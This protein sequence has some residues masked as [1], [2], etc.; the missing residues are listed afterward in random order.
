MKP[1]PALSLLSVLLLLL[2]SSPV[3]AVD[4]HNNAPHI[5]PIVFPVG[6]FLPGWKHKGRVR[7]FT[8]NGLYGHINGGSELFL[9]MGFQTLRLQK[10]SDA[11]GLEVAVEAYRMDSPEAALGIYLLN[12]GTETAFKEIPVRNTGD[13][14][15]L[16][17][18]KGRYFLK[19]NNFTG[20]SALRPAMVRLARLTL[21]QVKGIE[22]GDLFSIL[23]SE[24]RIKG[25]ELLFRGMY[26][27]QAIVT[28]GEGDVL[29][30]KDKVFGVSAQ[31]NNK[32]DKEGNT[33][34]LMKI[35]YPGRDYASEA[36][37]HLKA[38][39]DSYITVVEEGPDKLV[40]KD[41]RGK[42]GIVS[43]SENTLFITLD[44]IKLISS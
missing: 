25:S 1:L 12:C 32:E 36:F 3:R 8:R 39:L 18:I 13:N 4:S 35:P 27:L 30:L 10:Y 20:N 14:Y 17:M 2:I 15:Q 19:V 23:P 37:N 33:Y 38:N 28:L 26:S 31:Y 40:F 42:F 41:Y 16:M 34:R 7:T 24:N 44:L 9:E 6:D 43:L 22:P 11:Q 29:L 21:E 5:S